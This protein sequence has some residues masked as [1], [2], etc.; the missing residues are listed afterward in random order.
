MARIV[1]V[2]GNIFNTT[3]QVIV[4]TVNCEGVMGRGIALEFKN[5][6]P[7][8]FEKYKEFCDQKLMKPGVLQLYKKSTPWILNFPTKIFWKFPSKIDYIEKGLRKFVETY[9]EREI[10]SIAFPKLGTESGGMEWKEV[11]KVMYEYLESLPGLEVEIY[12]YDSSAVDNLFNR[13]SEITARFRPK[14]FVEIIGLRSTEAKKLEQAILS[15]SL[16]NMMDLQNI[17]GFGDSSIE[18]VYTFLK[19]SDQRIITSLE[20]DPELF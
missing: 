18:K 10:T 15:K 12:H 11:K 19:K 6:F 3:S 16:K 4:N 9:E 20:K 7:E 13:F 2:Y 5:R 17:K 1:E 8:M 14:D